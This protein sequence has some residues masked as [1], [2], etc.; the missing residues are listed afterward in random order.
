MSDEKKKEEKKEKAKI[1]YKEAAK[2]ILE[3]L[4]VSEPKV[5]IEGFRKLLAEKM[6]IDADTITDKQVHKAL[7]QAYKDKELK[8]LMFEMGIV[9][10]PGYLKALTI[11]HD[12]DHIRAKG[13]DNK[14]CGIMGIL[15]KAGAATLVALTVVAAR[16]VKAA[17]VAASAAAEVAEAVEEAAAKAA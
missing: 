7:Y 12:I 17:E 5:V 2:L 11:G 16:T 15:T 4:S 13:A 14:I 6:K 8:G 3:E 10:K 1:D 9:P